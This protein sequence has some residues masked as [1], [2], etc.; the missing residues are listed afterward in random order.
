MGRHDVQKTENAE[1]LRLFARAL[2]RDLRAFEKMLDQGLFETEVRRIGA[3]QEMF[4]VDQEF[5]PAMTAMEI[6]DL[7]DDPH[8]TTELGLFNLEC[9]LDPIT[10]G[11]S[12]LRNL[13]TQ[14]NE[15]L[16]KVKEAAQQVDTEVLLTGILPT[17]EKAD[18]TLDNMTPKPRYAALNEA[19]NRMRGERYHLYIKGRHELNVTH[20][21]VMLEA[22]NTSFQVHFQVKPESFARLYN[23]AQTVAAPVLAA[24]VNSPLLFGRQLWRETRI[25]LFQQSVDTRSPAGH[26][27]QLPSRVSFGRRWVDESVAEIYKEDIS[28]FRILMSTEVAEDPFEVLDRGEAPRLAALCL[29]NG[30]IYRWNRPCYGISSNGTPHLRIENRV[31]PSGPS[32]IDEIANA[33]L[34]FGLMNGIDKLYSDVTRIMDFDVARENF[35]SACRHGL[36][37][38]FDWPDRQDVSAQALLL[39][40]LI[41]L[42]REGL[43]DL[44]I[45]SSDVDR[46]LGVIEERVERLRTGASWL[47]DSYSNMKAEGNRAECLS[48]LVAA[49]L[50]R[51]RTG[52]PVHTWDPAAL[53]EAG[54]SRRYYARVGQLMTTDLFTVNQDE[55]V[56]VVACVMNWHHIRHVP[57]EDG[58][59]RI[60]GL[61]THRSLL[62][63]LAENAASNEG[64]QPV[65]VSQIMHKEVVTV[66]P[67]TPTLEAIRIMKERKISCLPV[68]DQR[69]RLVGIVSERD[70]MAIADHLVEAYL[71]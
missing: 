60:V 62:R 19:M 35:V 54:E 69:Q 58:D 51:Q 36:T 14:L 52:K 13:E 7:V 20:D 11:N 2:L 16:T 49:T 42:A 57:V 46:Y 4:L 44:R 32:P 5:R 26:M 41:P 50:S 38:H 65:P 12:A 63:L 53:W 21:N 48:A 1:E 6:L 25:A 55:L 40:E 56:D 29:H 28:R 43:K 71:S 47:V 22:C 61:V 23:I 30:T 3:E 70:F 59:H 39:E 17:L 67:D 33:A 66:S 15:L 45:D 8:F 68:V 24:A 34:W 27:R 9:N 31:L 18:L 10:L 37:A 64:Q